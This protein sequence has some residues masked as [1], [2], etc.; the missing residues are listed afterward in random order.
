MLDPV[1]IFGGEFRIPF[2]T[3]LKKEMCGIVPKSPE[4][5]F[6]NPLLKRNVHIISV[7]MLLILLKKFVRFGNYETICDTQYEIVQED[8]KKIIQLQLVVAEQLNQNCKCAI[9]SSGIAAF[10]E[11]PPLPIAFK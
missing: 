8:Y 3:V 9:R 11:M 6:A 10:A 5:L 7:Q 2:E 1:R 4:E